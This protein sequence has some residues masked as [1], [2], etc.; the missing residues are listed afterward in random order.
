MD[1]SPLGSLFMSEALWL[2]GETSKEDEGETEEPKTSTLEQAR[3]D[4]AHVWMEEGGSPVL[5][6][7]KA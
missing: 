7:S 2:L 1:S 3:F 4:W 5:A 6:E